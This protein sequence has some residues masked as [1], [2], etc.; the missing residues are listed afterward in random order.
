ME[1]HDLRQDVSDCESALRSID[2]NVESPMVRE[3]TQR[4]AEFI[5]RAL[6]ACFSAQVHRHG[7]HGNNIHELARVAIRD[8]EQ[9]WECLP[10][11][12]R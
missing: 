7:V 10:R 12:Y 8:A 11:D 4:K 3:I 2:R 6:L 9:L 5:R 1:S